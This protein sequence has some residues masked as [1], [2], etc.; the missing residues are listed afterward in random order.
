[1]FTV[2]KLLNFSTFPGNLA[3]IVLFIPST[4]LVVGAI[5]ASFTWQEALGIDR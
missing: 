2:S 4:S 5:M 1:M 3:I